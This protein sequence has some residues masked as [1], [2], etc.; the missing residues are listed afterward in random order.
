MLLRNKGNK[1]TASYTILPE[2]LGCKESVNADSIAA[3]LSPFNPEGVGYRV[4]LLFFWLSSPEIAKE[5][6]AMRVSMGGH[7]IPADTVERRYF[8]GLR[9]LFNMY[10]PVCDNWMVINN[11]GGNQEIVA[12]KVSDE[13]ILIKNDELWKAILTQSQHDL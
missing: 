1:T 3:G 13:Q 11:L 7:H 12:S 5:R 2:I 4:T 6:V 9:N 10:I 8:A